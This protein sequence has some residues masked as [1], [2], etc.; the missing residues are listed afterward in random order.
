MVAHVSKQL[1]AFALKFL[2][3]EQPEPTFE[4]SAPLARALND[5]VFSL[6][7][8]QLGRVPPGSYAFHSIL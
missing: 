7:L 4:E 3:F 2:C 5:K 6:L 8:S 1:F